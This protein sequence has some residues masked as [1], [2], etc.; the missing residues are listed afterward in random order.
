[1]KEVNSSWYMW[2]YER[3][4]KGKKKKG[5]YISELETQHTDTEGTDSV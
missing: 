3:D 4:R 1:M 5:S 2:W